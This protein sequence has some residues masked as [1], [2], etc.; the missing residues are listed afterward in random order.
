MF[1]YLKYDEFGR[2]PTQETVFAAFNTETDLPPLI[3][4]FFGSNPILMINDEK[5]AH[6]CFVTYNKHFTKNERFRTWMYD[7]VGDSIIF[8]PSGDAWNEKR[9]HLSAAFYMERMV[10]MIDI[11]AGN[12]YERVQDWKRDFASTG[13]DFA[14]FKETGNMVMD[15]V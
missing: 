14:I 12:V 9:K 13:K 11:V 1:K 3:L 2:L 6:D 7:L 15:C 5:I 4:V 8:S 10:K